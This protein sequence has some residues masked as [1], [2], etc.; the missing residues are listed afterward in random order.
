[1]ENTVKALRRLTATALAAG[2]VTV[3]AVAAAPVAANASTAV[4]SLGSCYRCITANG[5]PSE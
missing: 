5:M 3:G 4:S 1:M 2:L